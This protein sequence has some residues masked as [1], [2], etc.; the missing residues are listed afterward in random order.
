MAWWCIII[1]SQFL[2]K[3]KYT[4]FNRT[5]TSAILNIK[6]AISYKVP[7]STVDLCTKTVIVILCTLTDWYQISPKHSLKHHCLKN[8][9]YLSQTSGL[10]HFSKMAAQ[11]F[12]KLSKTEKN[13]KNLWCTKATKKL[14]QFIIKHRAK[15]CRN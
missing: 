8:Y 14:K 1:I 2:S 11:N 10:T 15:L 4:G 3:M 6:I 13:I 7:G 9:V 12:E 5:H